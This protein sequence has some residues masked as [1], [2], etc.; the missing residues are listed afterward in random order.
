MP[1]SLYAPAIDELLKSP[2]KMPFPSPAD[3]RDH[4]IYFLLV[5][6]FEN[7][8]APPRFSDPCNVY[9]GGNFA[10]IRKRLPYLKEL[11]VGAIWISPVLMNP[12][13]FKD[14]W[15]GYGIMDFM[16]IEPRFCSDPE[17]AAKDPSIADGELRQLVEDA[18]DHGIYVIFD[19]ILNHVGDLFDY[20]KMR[21][22]APWNPLGEYK[23]FW[24]NE[25]G[26]AQ[27]DWP[28]IGR[29]SD[30]PRNAGIW[31]REFQRNDYF[32]RRG[33]CDEGT[34]ITKG[35]FDRLK[36][37]VTEYLIPNTNLYP[38]RNLLIRAHQYL[39][40][41]FDVDF[42]SIPFSTSRATLPAYLEMPSGSMLFPSGK[43]TFS[44]PERSGRTMRRRR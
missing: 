34:D 14:Y 4:W 13:W 40:A 1:L 7:P 31:P 41:K 2:P 35:D 15:G 3:W 38:L 21:D 29:V 30:V 6:R 9:Q 24:R 44:H 43:R 5:D 10:G 39:I 23:I 28:D 32:R 19:I 18:H 42:A 27:A 8:A 17:A 36:E 26:V 12:P 22:S 20:E 33:S 37:L 25:E 11:G 16:R